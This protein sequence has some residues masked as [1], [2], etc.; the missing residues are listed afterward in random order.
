[1]K[2]GKGFILIGVGLVNLLHAIL[3]ILQFVQSFLI[4]KESLKSEEHQGIS[5]ILHSPVFIVIW[6]IVGIVTLWM[7]VRD[8]IHHRNCGVDKH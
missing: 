3:H 8:F 1:M 7:G 5:Y 4:V 6:T 2:K